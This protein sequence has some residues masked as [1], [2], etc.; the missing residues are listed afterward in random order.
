[1][2]V[3]L[4]VSFVSV[5]FFSVT[6]VLPAVIASAVL[7]VIIGMLGFLMSLAILTILIIHISM[8]ILGVLAILVVNLD[9]DI[10]SFR[11]IIAIPVVSTVFAD[12]V[13]AVLSYC[14]CYYGFLSCYA[15]F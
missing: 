4:G 3:L 5:L 14:C 13:V 12:S 7:I 10:P 2:L 9:F 15:G 11:A 6:P 8:I 1:M